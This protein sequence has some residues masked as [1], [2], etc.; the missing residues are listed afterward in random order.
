MRLKECHALAASAMLLPPI[1]LPHDAVFLLGFKRDMA[2][3]DLNNEIWTTMVKRDMNNEIW[4][5]NM[6][7]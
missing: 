1:I 7:N 5:T 3:R 4:T 2:N 6:D